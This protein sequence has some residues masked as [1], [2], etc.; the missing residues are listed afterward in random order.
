MDLPDVDTE[1]R[2]FE[3]Q[4]NSSGM[5]NQLGSG[6]KLVP[7]YKSNNLNVDFQSLEN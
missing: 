3:R 2:H 4:G 6:S 5:S 1:Q 7:N